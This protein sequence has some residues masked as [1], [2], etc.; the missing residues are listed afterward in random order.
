MKDSFSVDIDEEYFIDVLKSVLKN[1]HDDLAVCLGSVIT[2]DRDKEAVF[3]AALRIKPSLKY[4]V[5]D[6]IYV[7]LQDL[8]VYGI[9]KDATID[10][11]ADNTGYISVEV[12]DIKPY[13]KECYCIK[14][15]VVKDTDDKDKQHTTT[16]IRQEYVKGFSTEE[17]PDEEFKF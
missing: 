7:D 13:H 9:D 12:I 2:H 3:K 6:E 5:G 10:K 1:G 11:F 16:W 14:V 4:S 15:P 8:Y 17:F